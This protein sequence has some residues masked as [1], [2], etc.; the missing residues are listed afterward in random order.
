M[1]E[2]EHGHALKKEIE[3]F[4]AI[5]TSLARRDVMY[6]DH[7]LS[8]EALALA[9]NVDAKTLRIIM[10]EFRRGSNVWMP[11]RVLL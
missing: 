6:Q 9:K 7:F 5:K 11:D 1:Y 10:A 8:Q 4:Q 3:D 2:Q